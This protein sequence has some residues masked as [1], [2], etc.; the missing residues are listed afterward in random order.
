MPEN[1]VSLAD[2]AT[3]KGVHYQ[4]VRRA[5]GRGSLKATK[6]GGGVIIAEVDLDAWQPQ[7][8][9]A[10]RRY[11]REVDDEGGDEVAT[12][13]PAAITP[14]GHASGRTGRGAP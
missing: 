11:R 10:P 1:F 14:D 12:G 13:T 8:K 3:R 4:T 9:H 5:I 7:Y 6:V 2:A